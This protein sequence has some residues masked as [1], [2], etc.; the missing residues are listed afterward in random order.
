MRRLLRLLGVVFW[1]GSFFVGARLISI[2][3]KDPVKRRLRLAC[4]TSST[5]RHMLKPFHISVQVV[6]PEKLACLQESNHL[7]VGNHVS[8]TDIIVLSSLHPFVF[9][10]SQDMGE[11][12]L[13]GTIT[14]QGGCLYTERKKITTLPQEIY[15]FAQA[16]RDGFDV[17]LFPE[18]T[19]TNGETIRE[20]R[21]SLFQTSL[22]AEKPLLPICIRY[23]RLDGKP[24]MTQQQRDK[25]CWYGDM[26]FVP[27]L[28]EYLLHEVEVTVTVLDSIPY[29]PQQNRQALCDSVY[30][31]LLTAFSASMAD[32][33]ETN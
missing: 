26:E 22:I 8:Y 9:I 24:I 2:L 4:N 28:W 1:L 19:S 5:A 25:V 31:S 15:G 12:P 17:V 3:V 29:S 14:R 11:T 23:T 18:G 7:I 32:S 10:T 13:L 16:L 6:N 33:A 30:H 27:H 21:K 20:F